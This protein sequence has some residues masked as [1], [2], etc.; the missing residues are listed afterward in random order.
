MCGD[1]LF[2]QDFLFEDM[3]VDKH[4]NPVVEVTVSPDNNAIGYMVVSFDKMLRMNK[5]EEWEKLFDK[6]DQKRVY[7]RDDVKLQNSEMAEYKVFYLKT[8][9]FNLSKRC[10]SCCVGE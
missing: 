1:R 3:P 10:E 8:Y 4:D 7:I 9:F 6:I 2:F 5:K